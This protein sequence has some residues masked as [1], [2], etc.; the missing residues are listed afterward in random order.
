MF[1]RHNQT[2]LDMVSKN[3]IIFCNLC[4][5][6]YLFTLKRAPSW[7][8]VIDT[9]VWVVTRNCLFS[10][11]GMHS[12]CKMFTTK[13]DK[14]VFIRL[15]QTCWVFIL[16]PNLGKKV[17]LGKVDFSRKWFLRNRWVRGQCNST[18]LENCHHHVK[19]SAAPEV[20]LGF[21]FLLNGRHYM[22]YRNFGKSFANWTT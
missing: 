3:A 9:L 13:S 16:S 18:K 2:L 1:R 17:F 21:R 19:S 5:R 11:F 8:V 22:W 15:S 7:S 14:Y 20:V 10:I 6:D 4:I 12:M